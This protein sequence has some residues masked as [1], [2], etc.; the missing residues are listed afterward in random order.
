MLAPEILNAAGG[1]TE[2]NKRILYLGDLAESLMNSTVWPLLLDWAE[3]RANVSLGRLK[4]AAY[5]EPR[6]QQLFSQRWRTD[7]DWLR[8]LQVYMKG[9]VA[10]RDSLIE[11]YS[12]I[13]QDIKVNDL[14]GFSEVNSAPPET[15]NP[16]G[17]G[18]HA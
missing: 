11:T 9:L 10:D 5:A 12:R 8:D 13:T 2:E 16:N 1:I 15:E 17:K 14:P 4:G 6:I 18:Y 7:E 3:S